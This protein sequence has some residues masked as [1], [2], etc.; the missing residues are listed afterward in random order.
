MVSRYCVQIRK[1]MANGASTDPK[2][3]DALR[4]A[5]TA[6]LKMN[7]PRATIDRQIE[8]MKNVKL[9]KEMI[10]VCG[11]GR[12]CILVDVETDN[13]SRTRQDIKK[14]LKKIKG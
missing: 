12:S 7:V 9:R 10:E 14:I 6:A 5:I 4:N 11:P 2:I 3:N 1:T 13:I 8:K